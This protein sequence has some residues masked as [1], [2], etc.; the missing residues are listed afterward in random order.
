MPII[1]FLNDPKGANAN[2]IESAMKEE[3]ALRNL[4]R[5]ELRKIN[6]RIEELLTGEPS[7]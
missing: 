7:K 1:R 4:Q 2:T 6:K 3:E 5:G